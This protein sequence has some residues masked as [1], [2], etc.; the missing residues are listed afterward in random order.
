MS[1]INCPSCGSISYIIG[2]IPSSNEFAGKTLDEFIPGGNLCACKDCKLYFRSPRMDMNKLNALYKHA[3]PNHWQYVIDDRID[4]RIALDYL[5]SKHTS[6]KIIDFGCWDGSFLMNCIGFFDCYGIETNHTAAQK[7][8]ER[9]IKILSNDWSNV[10]IQAETFDSVVAFDVIEHVCDPK[11]FLS[12]IA[13]ITK[14]GGDILISTGNTD[15]LSWRIMRSKYWYCHISEHISFINI[16][17]CYEIGKKL[18]LKVKHYEKFSHLGNNKTFRSYFSELR[19]NIAYAFKSPTRS[20]SYHK[21]RGSD[22]S[23]VSK[24]PELKLKPPSWM[25]AKDHIIVIFGKI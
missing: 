20:V 8:I 21:E 6:G 7:A 2:P 5:S 9:G 15:A 16:N 1:L 18:N 19:K 24:F 13:S 11:K 17:W 25:S 10:S 14:N 3:N 12:N 22:K 23:E 4:W